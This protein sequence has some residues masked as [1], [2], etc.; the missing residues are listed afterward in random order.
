MKSLPLILREKEGV[1]RRSECVGRAL[2]ERRSLWRWI[3]PVLR[4]QWREDWR[5]CWPNMISRYVFAVEPMIKRREY[6]GWTL[7]EKRSFL[8][9]QKVLDG[10][11]ELE[12]FRLNRMG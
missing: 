8:R 5:N 3:C 4:Q 11:S 10:R 1:G 7:W 6:G 9:L 12:T 2:G